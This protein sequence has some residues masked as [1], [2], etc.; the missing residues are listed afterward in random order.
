MPGL[1][2]ASRSDR[3]HAAAILNDAR[4]SCKNRANARNG[5]TAWPFFLLAMH[6]DRIDQ[7][8]RT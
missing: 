1:V 7:V 5:T 3:R 4:Q 6:F 2:E 8:A